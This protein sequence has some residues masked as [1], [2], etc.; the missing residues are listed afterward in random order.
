MKNYIKDDG[1]IRRCDANIAKM[2]VFEYHWYHIR[3]WHYYR[4][5]MYNLRLLLACIAEGIIA[6]LWLPVFFF[7]LIIP[8]IELTVA[9]FKIKN[10][11][12]ELAK[13]KSKENDR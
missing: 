4:T 11:R 9:Q 3:Y 1:K 13:Y 6:L 12:K 10:A 2:N 7:D 8:V 5:E